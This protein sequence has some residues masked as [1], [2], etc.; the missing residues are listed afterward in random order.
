[1]NDFDCYNCRFWIPDLE[2]CL[3]PSYADCYVDPVYPAEL[4]EEMMG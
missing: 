4:Y 2:M 1:M 3:A